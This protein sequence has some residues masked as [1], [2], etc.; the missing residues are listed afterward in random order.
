MHSAG[1][2]EFLTW[3]IVKHDSIRWRWRESWALWRRVM[4]E[5]SKGKN[6]VERHSK[7]NNT[8]WTFLYSVWWDQ[9]VSSNDS[10]KRQT[11]TK[12]FSLFVAA[13]MVGAIFLWENNLSKAALWWL[14]NSD[15]L[16]TF[17]QLK[18]LLKLSFCVCSGAWEWITST[19]P[20]CRR[21]HQIASLVMTKIQMFWILFAT[22]NLSS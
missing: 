6:S 10:K 19:Y 11:Y 1:I 12:E 20:L 18:T 7:A 9:S 8:T 15:R 3:K 22:K 14:I 2:P 13:S 5:K 21:K 17:T 4:R 16:Q